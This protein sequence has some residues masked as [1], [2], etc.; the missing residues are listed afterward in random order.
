[1]NQIDG[2][3]ALFDSDDGGAIL[4]SD[5]RRA[6]RCDLPAAS[7]DT[8][9][10]TFAAIE[11][12][13]VAGEWVALAVDYGLGACFE[14]SAAIFEAAPSSLRGWVFGRQQ[15]LDAREVAAFL[16]RRLA[17]FSEQQ[18]YAGVA[19]VS[20]AL[21][22]AD[23]AAKVRQIK[24]W[25]EAGDCYQINLTFPLDFRVYGNPLALYS[26][27][28]QRQP[29]RYG[30]Y[31]SLPEETLLSCSP[32]L[33]FERSGDRVVTRPM[34][35]TAPRGNTPADDQARRSSLLASEKERAENI[36]IVDL[37]RNDLSRLAA[38]GAVRVEVLCEAEAYPTLW[39]V[40]STVSADLPGVSL[41]DLF[42][43]LFP[44]GSI[45]GAPKIRAM[46]CIAELENRPRGLYTGALGWLAPG[47]DCRF[48]VAIRT[49]QLEPDG[50]G[51]LGIGSGIV[52]DADPEREYAECLLKASFLTGFDPGFEL[53]ETLRLEDGEYPL[54]SYHLERLEA[55]AST[56]G[57]SGDITAIR[58]ALVEQSLNH[59]HGVFRVRLSL[60][61]NGHYRLEVGGMTPGREVWEAVLSD[62][63]LD[64]GNYLLRHKTTVRGSYNDALARLVETPEI[65]DA[66]F[67]NSRGEVCEGARSNVFIERDGRLVTP[68]LACGLLPGVM[69]RHLLESGRAVESLL[70]RDDLLGAPQVYLANALRG[71]LAVTLRI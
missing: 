46:Q 49:L 31:I 53:I 60:A 38:P 11:N 6:I 67:F 25:I 70:T 20:A 23:Y 30:A 18:R 63:I 19:E 64:P 9:E 4:L 29:V 68:P 43:A 16:E 15:R 71:L 62:E 54:L 61:H 39:Q 10:Q 50:R 35:G 55:S 12:A 24:Q 51:H 33:F 3:F 59:S 34:K 48:N 58:A 42:R 21:Q 57:F 40:A 13:S 37:L 36:M 69:R 45:T 28:R 41:F 66:I 47:G 52:I 5:Y 7:P 56:L 1:M 8:L 2:G 26:K 65:F 44:C 14:P 17:A 32:E 22:G 27:L